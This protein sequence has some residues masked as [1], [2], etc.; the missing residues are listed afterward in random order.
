MLGWIWRM[1]VGRFS[2]CEHHWEVLKQLVIENNKND[3]IGVEYHMKCSKC[4]E[5]K[6]K[7]FI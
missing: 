3:S 5:I 4:G 6:S 2:T 1:L 7:K